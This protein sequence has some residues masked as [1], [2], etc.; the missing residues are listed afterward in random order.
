M[1][2]FIRK[3]FFSAGI[4]LIWLII[5]IVLFIIFYTGL[6]YLFKLNQED[7]VILRIIKSRLKRKN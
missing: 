6:L 7:K 1:I 2:F 4:S 5:L 3:Y